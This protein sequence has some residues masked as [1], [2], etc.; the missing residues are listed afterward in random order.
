ML[1]CDDFIMFFLYP[2][3]FCFIGKNKKKQN[4]KNKTKKTK[5]KK[6][7]KNKKKIHSKKMSDIIDK[8]KFSR[9]NMKTFFERNEETKKVAEEKNNAQIINDCQT[10]RK[11]LNQ[12]INTDVYSELQKK[13][14][15]SCILLTSAP[16]FHLHS[17][18][19]FYDIRT[20]CGVDFDSIS[21]ELSDVTQTKLTVNLFK[22][23][24][25]GTECYLQFKTDI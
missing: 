20:K 2:F 22:R 5:Q 25:F 6:H 4:K 10:L 13:K 7:K 9:E 1:C 17:L 16:Y 11:A 18:S 24:R 12:F 21:K 8:T 3:F 15:H 19:N 23:Y 14:K